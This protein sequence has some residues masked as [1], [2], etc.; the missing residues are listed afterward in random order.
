LSSSAS[1]CSTQEL[2]E[3]K[4]VMQSKMRDADFKSAGTNRRGDGQTD[5]LA[6]SDRLK[7][8]F[9]FFKMDKSFLSG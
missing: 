6:I 1:Q 3:T 5:L 9:L 8:Q 2:K 7:F 4:D